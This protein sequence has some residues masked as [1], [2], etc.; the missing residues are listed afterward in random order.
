MI[1][2]LL[3]CAIFTEVAA[4]LCL[5]M[6]D[7][8]EKWHYGSASIALYAISGMIFAAVLKN[9]GIGVAYAI[10]SGMGIALIVT[11]SV[12]FWNQKFDTYAVAGIVLILSGTLLMTSKS[13]VV[14]Q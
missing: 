6:S 13:A 10:W 14:F 8:W 5:K 11:A 4:T 9:M 7:G 3:A 2:V 1:Y 12:V